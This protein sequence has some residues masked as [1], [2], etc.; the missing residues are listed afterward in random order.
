MTDIKHPAADTLDDKRTYAADIDMSR[1]AAEQAKP[2]KP[3]GKRSK[4]EIER[5]NAA[6]I[7]AATSQ[8]GQT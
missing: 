4:D 2:R 7:A 8:T 5:D 1:D 6:A 3:A